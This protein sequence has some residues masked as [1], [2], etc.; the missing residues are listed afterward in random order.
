MFNISSI[1]P[2]KKGYEFDSDYYLNKHMPR[3]IEEYRT[4]DPDQ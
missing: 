2:K 4:D 1:Y 3:S